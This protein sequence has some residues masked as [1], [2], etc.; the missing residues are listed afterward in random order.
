MLVPINRAGG[1][2]LKKRHGSGLGMM[3][4]LGDM[5]LKVA[6]VPAFCSMH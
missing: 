6:G 2:G 4:V 3:T 5:E 1:K